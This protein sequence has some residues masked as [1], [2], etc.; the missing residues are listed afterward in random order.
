M[1]SCAGRSGERARATPLKTHE[2]GKDRKSEISWE[3]RPRY[4]VSRTTLRSARDVLHRRSPPLGEARGGPPRGLLPR[5]RLQP[6]HGPRRDLPSHRRG[7]RHGESSSQPQKDRGRVPDGTR[8]DAAVQAAAV[9]RR[10][11]EGLRR[12]GPGGREQGARVREPGVGGAEDRGRASVLHRRLGLATHQGPRRAAGGGAERE[13][14][15][16]DH[17]GGAQFRGAPRPGPE[18]HAEPHQRLHE[19]AQAHAE[20]DPGGVH[21]SRSRREGVDE[22]GPEIATGH[23]DGCSRRPAHTLF[24]T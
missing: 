21:G 15:K 11:A 8:R 20:E 18:P 13:H 4:L 7:R 5:D 10:E 2:S 1:R 9:L 22:S 14:A 23:R 3:R 17:A 24:N 12:G 19:H 16:G 6:R